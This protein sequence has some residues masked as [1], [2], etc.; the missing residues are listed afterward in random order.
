[1]EGPTAWAED[2]W[3][4]IAIGDLHLRVVKPCSR[5]KMPNIDQETSEVD[6]VVTEALKTFRYACVPLPRRMMHARMGMMRE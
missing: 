2:G 6:M 5:C 3:H 4:R 1:M